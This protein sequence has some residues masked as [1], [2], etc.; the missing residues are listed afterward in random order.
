M[1]LKIC[2]HYV[3]ITKHEYFTLMQPKVT[4]VVYMLTFSKSVQFIVKR[5]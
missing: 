4:K 1:V 3:R 2:H 5:S